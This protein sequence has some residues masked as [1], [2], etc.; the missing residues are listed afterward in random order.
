MFLI[1]LCIEKCY[2][3]FFLLAKMTNANVKDIFLQV[4]VVN[5]KVKYELF[6]L[7]VTLL[8]T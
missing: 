1:L 8:N 4:T 3:E 6:T 2:K 5:L 7:S